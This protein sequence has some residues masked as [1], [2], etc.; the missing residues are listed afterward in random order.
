MVRPSRLTTQG[1]SGPLP[2]PADRGQTG[3]NRGTPV[4]CLHP[5]TIKMK[6]PSTGL[7]RRTERQAAEASDMVACRPADATRQ[8]REKTPTP[9]AT[10]VRP[11][12]S[13]YPLRCITNA[14]LAKNS[15]QFR[16]CGLHARWVN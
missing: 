16:R 7:T 4:K 1:P 5:R 2:P 15:L 3:S 6:R 10:V 14:T 8:T 12:R 11:Q 13:R 9:P